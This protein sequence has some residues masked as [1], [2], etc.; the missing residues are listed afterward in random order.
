MPVN[1]TRNREHYPAR[2][3]FQAVNSTF[4][5]LRRERLA[6]DERCA[7][8]PTEPLGAAALWKANIEGR[9]AT[10]KLWTDA[11]LAALAESAGLAMVTFDRGFRQF[12][13]SR[14]ELL[15]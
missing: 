1:C 2:K 3:K 8:M 13:L 11:W 10:P 9:A 12:K 14:L 15:L 4:L 6:L 7:F 5:F